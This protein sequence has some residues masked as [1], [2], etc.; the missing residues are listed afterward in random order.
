M[1]KIL[2]VIMALCLACGA[3]A[4]A[5]PTGTSINQD[6]QNKNATTTVSYTVD[7][8]QEYTV[9]IPSAVTLTTSQDGQSASGSG[10]LT[11]SDVKFNVTGA[12]CVKLLAAANYDETNAKFYLSSGFGDPIEYTITDADGAPVVL[13]QDLLIWMEGYEN[14]K[15]ENTLTF[16]VSDLTNA[17]GGTEYTDTL[18]FNVYIDNME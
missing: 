17:Y 7:V 16:T 14:N 1:K 3:V 15:A 12:V 11:M 13:E 8:V 18:T 10:R 4:F 6:S 5:V 2:A 9:T